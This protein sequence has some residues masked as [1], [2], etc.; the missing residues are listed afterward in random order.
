[1]T[2]IIDKRLS[3]YEDKFKDVILMR[4]NRLAEK[5][6]LSSER[7]KLDMIK[8]PQYQKKI[9]EKHT[10]TICLYIKVLEELLIQETKKTQDSEGLEI[11]R[12]DTFHKALIACSIETIFF[13]NNSSNVNFVKLLELCEI[14][15]FDFWKVIGSFAKF[16]PQMP[17]PIKK[18]LYDIELKI[19]MYLAWKKN[20]IVFHIVNKSLQDQKSE[21]G[22]IRSLNLN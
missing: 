16:D 20:S 12:C 15:A 2:S 5:V 3:S 8:S 17:Y 9:K 1:M 14:E 11:L 10:Q 21:N 6:L 22:I 18:H 7:E 4:V 19:L 13:V